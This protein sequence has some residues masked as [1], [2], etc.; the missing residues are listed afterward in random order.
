ML[1]LNTLYW[2]LNENKGLRE[3]ILNAGLEFTKCDIYR[4]IYDISY[5]ENDYS[6]LFELTQL[7]IRKEDEI[8][9]I[10]LNIDRV[11]NVANEV[12]ENFI[13]FRIVVSDFKYLNGTMI[14]K[15]KYLIDLGKN[16]EIEIIVDGYIY[17]ELDENIKK[18]YEVGIRIICIKTQRFG[19]KRLCGK[20][21]F[22]VVKNINSLSYRL[23]GLCIYATSPMKYVLH[24]NEHTKDARDIRDIFID[25]EGY[26]GTYNFFPTYYEHIKN[27]AIY[28][29]SR[30]IVLYLKQDIEF[31]FTRQGMIDKYE[32]IQDTIKD[33]FKYGFYNVA[34]PHIVKCFQI[35]RDYIIDIRTGEQSKIN[36]MAFKILDLISKEKSKSML[37]IANEFISTDSRDITGEG[38]ADIFNFLRQLWDKKIIYIEW[39]NILLDESTTH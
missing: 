25:K 32:S 16:V 26:I 39:R 35:K 10:L 31:T 29:W 5:L 11:T 27:G 2:E 15:I 7:I 33:R 38:Y 20:E 28:G 13:N 18:L 30:Y 17:K 24:I 14:N 21:M 6:C 37:E 23:E 8:T 34:I 9:Y 4:I 12:W 19:E 1:Q 3:Y 36:Q 22:A